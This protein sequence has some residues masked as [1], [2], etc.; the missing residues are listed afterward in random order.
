MN[1]LIWLGCLSYMVIG[2]AHVVAGAVLVPLIGAYGVEYGDGG[3]FIMNQFVGFLVG[4]LGAPLVTRRLGRRSAL[5]LALS[6]LTVAE[7]AYSLLLPWGWMLASAPLA[8]FGFGMTEAVLGAI[9]IEFVTDGKASA[10]AKL[11]TFFGI[12]ALVM[13]ILAGLL[14][15][16]DVWQMAFP[17]VTALSGITM[18]LW[19]TM[20]FGKVDELIAYRAAA[21]ADRPAL[22]PA[23]YAPAAWPL[24]L[25]GTLYFALYVGMEMSYS[26]YL[27]AILLERTDMSEAA[28]SASLSVFWGLMVVGRMFAGRIADRSG[29]FRYLL[30]STAAGT[31]MLVMLAL[32]GSAGASLLWIGLAGLLWSGVFAVAL[33]YVNQYIPGMTERTT[34]L[35]I[36]SGGVGGALLPR[37]TG[38][39]MDHYGAV[40]TLWMIAAAASLL[41]ALLGVMALTVRSIRQSNMQHNVLDAGRH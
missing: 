12:G 39:I 11:E 25:A 14:I 8:G 13:P 27:P 5:I 30:I 22:K 37:T 29:Y 4:V 2:M 6:C 23:R 1:R 9:I 41:I 3:Q 26:N 36:A 19:L 33:L 10:M 15:R 18:L 21:A 17:I 40:G 28:A 35:L 38:W 32:T 24:L 7:A 31:G 16:A 20:S 34:S